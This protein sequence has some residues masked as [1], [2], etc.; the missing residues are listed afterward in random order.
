M[1]LIQAGGLGY[2]TISTV[3]A[4][5]LGRSVS[6]QE[7]LTLQEAL[8]VAG[9]G[10]P[11]ALRRHGAEADAGLR[12][13]RRRSSSPLR[14][15]PEM[16]VAQA[17]WYGLFHAVSAFNNAGFALWSDNLTRVARR[18]HGQPGDHRPDHRRRARLLRAGPSS[19]GC[20]RRARRCRC[21]RDWCWSP[22]RC[23]W[24]AGTLAFLV[25]EWNNP[26]TLAGAGRSASGC[27]RPGSSR[28]PPAPPASTPSTS[29]RMTAAGAVRDDG[30]DV[31]RRVARQHR[32]RRQ[33][34][35]VQHHGGGAVGDGAR[36]RRH[37]DLQAAAGAPRSSPRPSSSRS[38]RSWR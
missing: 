13:D 27:W 36:R 29:A 38:S 6:L 11:G 1:L 22:P 18:R 8:N 31:H 12:A 28:S 33:D 30:A 23:C 21:T 24:S 35:D 2:M 26:R 10:R 25:L 20:D 19:S 7:R 4:A 15:W 5:A 14:W 3:L 9:H 34:D 17:L 32:R 16:G 37:G